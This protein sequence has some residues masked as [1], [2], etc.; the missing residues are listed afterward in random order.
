MAAHLD[1]DDPDMSELFELIDEEED[2]IEELDFDCCEPLS[3]AEESEVEYQYYK[4][5]ED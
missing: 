4:H 3:E 2:E 5:L 1:P